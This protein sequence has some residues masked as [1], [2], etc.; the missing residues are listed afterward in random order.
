M[1]M[2]SN[3]GH[4]GP[5][6]PPLWIPAFAGMTWSFPLCPSD[7][8]PAS[9]GNLTTRPLWIP[10]FAGMTWGFPLCPSDIS[11]ASEGNFTTRPLWIPAFAGM[12]WSFPLCPSD[13]S[14]ASGG[15][16]GPLGSGFRRNDGRVMTGIAIRFL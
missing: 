12:T 16:P 13:I 6:S 10:A 11:P 1:A 14:P 5:V 8:S 3:D 4:D 7:I 9:E 2:I 15:N